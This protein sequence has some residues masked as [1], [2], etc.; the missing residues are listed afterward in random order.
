MTDDVAVSQETEVPRSGEIQTD[1]NFGLTSIQAAELLR[2]HGPNLV[3]TF[4][5]R[6]FHVLFRQLR[7][8]LMVLLAVTTLLAFFLGQRTDALVITVIMLASITLGFVN[9]YRAERTAIDLHARM[10]HSCTV[11][12]DGEQRV[13]SVADVVPGDLVQLTMGCVV[14]ADAQVI[15]AAGLECNEGILTGE[16]TLAEKSASG[17]DRVFM[18]TVVS[19]GSA[20]AIVTATSQDTLFGRMSVDLGLP[21]PLTGFQ[22]GLRRFS[23]LLL[24]MAGVLV[25]AVVAANVV[26]QR[27]WVEALLFALAICVGVTPQMLPAVVSISLATGAKRL[28]GSQVLV[29]R[30]I[31]IEDLG[32]IEVLFTDKTGTL[33]DGELQFLRAINPA[34]D[35]DDDLLLPALLACAADA[36]GVKWSAGAN[37]LDQAVGKAAAVTPLLAEL[38]GYEQFAALPFDHER[39]RSSRLIRARGHDRLVVKG[40]AES[41]LPLCIG[42]PASATR[43]LNA[44]YDRGNRVIALASRDFPKHELSESRKQHTTASVGS[45]EPNTPSPLV[46]PPAAIS[47]DD[48]TDL[49]LLG[50]LVFADPVKESAGDALRQ[51]AALGISIK[52]LT[53]DHLT[54]AHRVCDQLGLNHVAG[55]TGE[56]IDQLDDN[57]LTAAVAATTIFAR[58]NPSQ[59]V[60]IVRAQRAT[61]ADVAFLGDGVNDAPALHEADVGISVNNAVDVAQDAADIILL[62]KDLGVLAEGVKQGR[63]VFANTIKYVLMSA[64]SNFGNMF[65]AAGAS[66]LLP[67][68]PMLPS[69]VLLNNLLYD[70]SQLTICTDNA[71]PEQLRR[72]SHWDMRLIRRYMLFFGLIS[73]LFDF[74]TFA[75]LLW[76]FHAPAGQ[77]QAG[78]FA[79]SLATQTLVVLVIRTRRSPFWRSRPSAPLLWSVGAVV[80]IGAVLPF[81]ALA[82]PLGF[83]APP[84]AQLLA[85]AGLVLAYLAVVEAGK[86]LLQGGLQPSVRD[87]CKKPRPHRRIRRLLRRFTTR[88][89]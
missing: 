75:L 51:L 82:A 66:M 3:H 71:D 67:F 84:G 31:S 68:L 76:V 79:E 65:S 54:V 74:S 73:S 28:A 46:N 12:R 11:V 43:V 6:W 45:D 88:D 33:T 23:M 86:H 41:V 26:L 48:E 49:R 13:I 80:A 55:L 77:F 9:E 34:G 70:A 81:T 64:S 16:S 29:K 85:M 37:A 19:A 36:R 5:V 56:Q 47:V 27:S 8:P 7:S 72:P 50:F 40:A 52:V 83:I 1:A 57:A 18:G 15:E 30:L 20:R 32:D 44:E 58:L 4:S 10:Q 35:H 78:W 24:V 87:T 60:R 61:G 2:E 22:A 38:S 59:K 25:A 39:Q 69:Q 21:Q 42:T 53:G 63:R 14:P 89:G 62:R 17:D